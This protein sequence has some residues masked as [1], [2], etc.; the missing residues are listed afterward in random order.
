VVAEPVAAGA[1]VGPALVVTLVVPVVA[2]LEVVE[3]VLG[4]VG[5][6]VLFAF[7]TANATTRTTTMATQYQACRLMTSSRVVVK[8]EAQAYTAE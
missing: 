8:S 6:P 2:V 7:Q 5:P 1:V 3:V 4:A